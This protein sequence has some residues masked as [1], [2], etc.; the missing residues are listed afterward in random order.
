LM[1]N[2]WLVISN[3]DPFLHNVH[4]DTQND[5]KAFNRADSPGQSIT[6]LFSK[7]QIPARVRCDVH[8]WMFAYVCV[9][10]NPFYAVTD[11]QGNYSISNVPPGKYVLEAYHRKAHGGHGGTEQK[12]AVIEGETTTAN[13]II[14]SPVLNGRVAERP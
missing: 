7:P 8:P 13:F 1:V 6:C 10:D 4:V 2:Q 12:I 5:E 14:Q 3:S 9:V 11:A